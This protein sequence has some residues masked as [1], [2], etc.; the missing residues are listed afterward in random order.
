MTDIPAQSVSDDV[1]Y[2]YRPSLLGAAWSFRLT[3][4]GM[5][6]EAGRKSG[7]IPYRAIRG[8][9]LSFK[10]ASMQTQRYLTEIWAEGAPKLEIVSSS[11]KSMVEQERL[12]KTYAA[13]VTELH[14]RIAQVEGQGSAPVRYEQGSP[15]LLYWPGLAVFAGVALGLAWLTVRALQSDAMA[16]AAFIAAFMLLFLW[17]GGNFFRRNRPGRYRP[18]ALPDVLM[19][20]G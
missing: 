4:G 9:R 3:A 7:L 1:A 5:A 6:W 19:P 10:P 18:D 20:K 15:P 16:G 13:F 12:D 2:S 11:W 8:V 17:Q 14:R